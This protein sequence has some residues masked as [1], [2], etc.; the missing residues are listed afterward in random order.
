MRLPALN[1]TSPDVHA[2]GPRSERV[3]KHA[4]TAR[5][6]RMGR[7]KLWPKGSSVSIW[8]NVGFRGLGLGFRIWGLGYP[9]VSIY[10]VQ[11]RISNGFYTKNPLYGLGQYFLY[12]YLGS[13]LLDAHSEP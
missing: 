12:R 6:T 8:Y 1:T 11:R 10:M 3:G 7:I 4:K 13:L 2:S 5:R 9:T